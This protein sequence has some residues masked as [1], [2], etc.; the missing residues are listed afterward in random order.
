MASVWSTVDPAGTCVYAHS[1]C[2]PAGARPGS[3]M[4]G[5]ATS[6]YG[7]S[8]WRPA[9]TSL[10][11]RWISARVPPTCSVPAFRS[12]GSVHGTGPE[13]AKSTLEAALP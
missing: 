12:S 1:T 9:A 6:T 3:S 4:E 7:S 5:W 8:L 10:S 2:F 13:S 11:A